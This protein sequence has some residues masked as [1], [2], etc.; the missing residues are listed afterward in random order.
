M[1]DPQ[2]SA[3]QMAQR[4]TAQLLA[5][6]PA[7]SAVKVAQRLVAIQGQDPRGA[8]LAIRARTEGLTAAD[9][10]RALTVDRSLAITWLNRGTLHLIA[11]EDYWWLHRLTARPQFQIGCRRI[12]ARSGVTDDQADRGVSVIERALSADGPLTRLQVRDRIARAGLPADGN[13]VLHMLMLASLRGIA[14]RGPMAG[15]HHAYAHVHEWFGPPPPPLD[16]DAALAELA[17]RYLVGHGPASDRDLAK[18][19]GL[20]VGRARRGLIA[21]AAELRDRPDGLAELSSA[22]APGGLPAPR[23]LGPYD[24]VLLGWAS[25]EPILGPHQHIVTVNG[26]FRPF[27]LVSGRAAGMWAWAR[28]RVELEPFSELPGEVLAA[29]AAEARDV[30]RFLGV[31]AE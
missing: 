13:V 25:R 21:I 10:D 28:G 16:D 11:S 18:W 15:A 14:V 7:R 24:P 20:T 3:Q 23:L 5:G 9:V 30:Q 8:R 19:A 17:R 2:V 26:L 4:L 1:D 31:S 22:A 6:T 29:L 12:L 27:A